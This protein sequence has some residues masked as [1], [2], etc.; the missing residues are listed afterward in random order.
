MTAQTI[1]P[2]APAGSRTRQIFSKA[3]FELLILVLLLLT[4]AAIRFEDQILQRTQRV[5]PDALGAY[6]TFAQTDSTVG[7]NTVIT[8]DA[9]RPMRWSCDL[10]PG[11]AYP[12]CGYEV[13]VG[14]KAGVKG[15][16]LSNLHSIAITL[17]YT[18]PAKTLRFHL[19]NYDPHYSQPG[20][21]KSAKFN[22]VEFPSESGK[23]QT[24]TFDLSDFSV[25]D[26]WLN[27][28][29]IP[30][31]FGHPQ[32]D[33][34]TSLD[35]QTGTEAPL[36]VHRFEV[37]EIV[38]RK[39]ALSTAQWYLA[40]LGIWV[41]LIGAFLVYRIRNLKNELSLRQ[42]SE[43]L[44]LRQAVEAERA[45]RHDHL[46]SVLNRRGAAEEFALLPP[47]GAVALIL[48]DIDRFKMLNDRFG[49]GR[50]DDVL[51]SIATLIRRNV[52]AGDT[53]ARWG[54][55]EFLILCPA[56][57]ET[58]AVTL[59]E[60]IRLRIEHARFG[61]CGSVT[62]SFGVHA[63][64]TTDAELT[65]L[66]SMADLALYSAKRQG[67]NRVLPFRPEMADAA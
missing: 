38:L 60:K 4:V 51:A 25:A 12:F 30:P 16:D 53:V 55:E 65:E 64:E 35:F 56:T 47:G 43:A 54:G 22:K 52:R 28:N 61:A 3:R 31:K 37:R 24:V 18:G 14:G 66:V 62:A 2:A 50:G 7:G 23:V 11:F 46:T 57:D 9:T 41:V 39:A 21:G 40:L 27:E 45:A 59:A 6:T 19:K 32:F 5:T 36:G 29:H 34:I 33:N 13:E 8:P 1:A 42:A 67:R 63:A 17:A 44:T 49:H 58:A 26:W 15:I 48:I 10:R 20:V